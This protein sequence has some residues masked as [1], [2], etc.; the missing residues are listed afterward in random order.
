MFYI[1]LEIDNEPYELEIDPDCIYL[2]CPKCGEHLYGLVTMIRPSGDL[3]QDKHIIIELCP[4]CRNRPTPEEA[5]L[6]YA[7]KAA[8]YFRKKT[9]RPITGEQILSWAKEGGAE[10]ILKRIGRQFGKP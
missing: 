3:E 5:Q 9:G 10:L 2:K 1:G 8:A 4:N 7:E 6:Q